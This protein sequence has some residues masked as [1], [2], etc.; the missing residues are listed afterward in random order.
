MVSLRK[1][2]VLTRAFVLQYKC[3]DD[4]T[5][6]FMEMGEASRNSTQER[7]N[8][9]PTHEVGSREKIIAIGVCLVAWMTYRPWRVNGSLFFSSLTNRGIIIIKVH[10]SCDSLPCLIKIA[11]S[12]DVCLYLPLRI[13]WSWLL[14]FKWDRERDNLNGSHWKKCVSERKG[15]I[16]NSSSLNF[17]TCHGAWPNDPWHDLFR[18]PPFSHEI[19]Y[20][21]TAAVW[22]VFWQMSPILY[23]LFVL[24]LWLLSFPGSLSKIGAQSAWHRYYLSPYLSLS[25]NPFTH[26]VRQGE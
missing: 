14:K 8:E 19:Q 16:K 26:I 15:E 24:L 7:D 4:H 3:Y 20:N 23:M 9:E 1:S 22:K 10:E 6:W 11:P 5:S 12:Q 17:L 21:C 13:I 25:F 18:N 2:E